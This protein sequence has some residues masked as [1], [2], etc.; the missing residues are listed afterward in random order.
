MNSSA[1]DSS[2]IFR[3]NIN[4]GFLKLLDLVGKT[5]KTV[6][7]TGITDYTTPLPTISTNASRYKRGFLGLTSGYSNI[8]GAQTDWYSYIQIIVSNPYSYL[9]DS[10]TTATDATGRGILSSVKDSTGL[11]TRKYNAIKSFYKASYNID[12]QEIGNGGQ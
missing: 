9:T 8:P 12:L 7:F 11:I 10:N 5:A 2:I 4:Y 3:G 6:S 1:H